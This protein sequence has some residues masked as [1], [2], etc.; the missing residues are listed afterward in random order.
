MFENWPNDLI[1]NTTHSHPETS[2]SKHDW[3]PAKYLNALH[4]NRTQKQLPY[5]F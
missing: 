1:Y 4:D 3:N 5:F 2:N